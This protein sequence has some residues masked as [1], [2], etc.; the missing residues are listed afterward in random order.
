M[1]TR[2]CLLLVHG[3]LQVGQQLVDVGLSQQSAGRLVDTDRLARV[4]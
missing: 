4:R 2:I 1:G 3:L